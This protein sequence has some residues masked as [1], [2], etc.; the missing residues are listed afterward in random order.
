MARAVARSGAGRGSTPAAISRALAPT[1]A[2]WLARSCSRS[3]MS[4]SRGGST[5]V[6]GGGGGGMGGGRGSWGELASSL[7]EPGDQGERE[8]EQHEGQCRA[9][10]ALDQPV[11]RLADVVEDLQGK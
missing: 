11:L 1:G 9:P 7:D 5:G 4:A 2:S 6:A 8:D 3:G 10:C